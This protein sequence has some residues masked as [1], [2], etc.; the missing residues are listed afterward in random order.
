MDSDTTTTIRLGQ[1]LRYLDSIRGLSALYVAACHAYLMYAAD[2]AEQGLQSTSG[3]LLLATSWLVWGRSAVAVFIVV[4][5]YC[6]MLPV[7]Q[8]PRREL[9]STFFQFMARRARRILPPYYAALAVSIVLILMVPSLADPAIGEW[10][11]SFPAISTGSIASHLLLLHN[12]VPAHQYAIDHPLWSIA[13][14]WQIYLLFPL[15]VAIGS[16]HGDFRILSASVAITV[17]LNMSLVNGWFEHNPWP[18]QFVGLFGLGM[19]CAAWNFPRDGSSPADRRGWGRRATVLLAVGV[20]SNLVF[21]ATRQQVPD[22]LIGAGLGCALVFLTDA[23]ARGRHPLALRALELPPLVELGR[24]SYQPLPPPR[25]S[26][27]AVL[28]SGTPVESEHGR[29]PALHPR[30]CPAR[31]GRNL[32]PV[33]PDVRTAI[34]EFTTEAGFCCCCARPRWDTAQS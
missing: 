1:R 11:K 10:H 12:Y 17:V 29:V 32:L 8:S 34:S 16:K 30:H 4:S 13:T 26:A 9:R 22:L 27:G 2:F 19:V 20:A 24:F 15:L 33:L 25:A 28:P 18:P 21:G 5:G 3:S 6:L 14:E 23:V 7:V 31:N